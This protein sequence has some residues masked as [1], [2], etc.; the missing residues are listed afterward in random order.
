M[1]YNSFAGD[2]SKTRQAPWKDWESFLPYLPPSFSAL[3]LG[4]GN[5]RL[6]SFLKNYGLKHY[7]GVDLSTGLLSEARKKFPTLTFIQ[8]DMSLPLPIEEK[9][10]ALFAIASFHHLKP[11]EQLATLKQ[12]KTY[13]RPGGQLFMTNWNLHQVRFWKEFLSSYLKGRPRWLHIPWKNQVERTYYAFT[14]RRLKYL[15][16]KAGFT[17][18]LHAYMKKGEKSSFLKGE[19]LITIATYEKD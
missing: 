14:L 6:Y 10:D 19:N 4:C 12:W 2:F 15:L 9:F 1:D 16:K 17:L 3:D 8:A 5:G 11:K 7:L 18:N 13:L